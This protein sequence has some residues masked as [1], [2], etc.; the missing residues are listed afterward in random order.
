MTGGNHCVLSMLKCFYCTDYLC[1]KINNHNNNNI[2]IIDWFN[3]TMFSTMLGCKLVL[4]KK[5]T[6]THTQ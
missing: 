3:E 6:H 1:N 5:H 2:I 4:A